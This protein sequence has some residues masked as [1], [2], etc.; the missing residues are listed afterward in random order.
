MVRQ[1]SRSL[2]LAFMFVLG[3]MVGEFVFC[4][5]PLIDHQHVSVP[6]GQSPHSAGLSSPW[7]GRHVSELVAAI[8]EPDVILETTVRGIAIYGPTYAVSYVY[9]PGRGSGG[10]CYEA[11]VVE[12]DSGEILAHHCR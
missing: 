9:A 2:L 4:G 10:Q 7:K 5:T 8:G 11:Y 3:S 1:V 6:V 12:H